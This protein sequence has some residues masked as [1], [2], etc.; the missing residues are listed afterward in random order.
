[1]PA[2]PLQ[3]PSPRPSR[4]GKNNFLFP[5]VQMKVSLIL[6]FVL[7]AMLLFSR[8]GYTQ[9][10]IRGSVLDGNKAP[11]VNATI[12]LLNAIDSSDMAKTITNEQG[13]YSFER[14]VIGDYII[15]AS[16]VGFEAAYTRAVS[17]VSSDDIIDARPIIMQSTSEQLQ[18]VV[19]RAK[20]PLIEQ[21]IDRTIIHVKSSITSAGITALDVL[22]R[23]PGVVVNRQNGLISM[24]GKEGVVVMINGKASYMPAAAVVQMLAGMTASNIDKVEL[25]TTPPANYD[26]EG[27][28]G[29]IN[30]VTTNNPDMGMNGSVSGSLGYGKGERAAASANFN[31]RKS[32]FNLYGDYSFTLD[33]MDQLFSFSRQ[34]LLNSQ[35]ISNTT[36][37]N[38]ETTQRNHLARI[39]FDFNLSN[40]TT[41]SGLVSMYNNR[42]SM[43]AVN[44]N[45]TSTN[46]LPDTSRRIAN[47]EINHWKHYGANVGIQHQLSADAR[48]VVN[49]DYLYY[50]DNNPVN[51]FN[52][53]FDNQGKLLFEQQTRSGKETP[54]KIWVGSVDYNQR[55]SKKVTM[56][57]GVKTSIS[58]FENNVLIE[59]LEQGDWV[60]DPSL[61]ARY[62]LNEDIVALYTSLNIIPD[63]K[64]EIKAG[65]RYEYTNSNLGTDEIKDVVDR[66][67]G[68]LFPGIFVTRKLN[69]DHSVGLSYSRRI[70]RPTFNDMAPFVIFIDPNTFFA[71]NPALR[72]AIGDNIKADYTFRKYLFSLSYNFNKDA[73]ARF[74]TQ[75]DPVANKQFFTSENL[76]NVKTLSAAVSFP[77]TMAAWWSMQSNITGTFQQVNSTFN[78][79]PL[80]KE[81]KSVRINSTQS[82]TLPKDF[83]VELSGFYQT[84]SLFGT[85]KLAGHGMFNAGIQKKIGKGKLRFGVDDVFNTF[86]YET[87]VKVPDENFISNADYKFTQRTYKLTYTR[88]F[89][90][91]KLKE[92][93]SRSMGSE[94]ERARVN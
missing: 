8:N 32:K 22:E 13:R 1:M 54:I 26:A 49:A 83:A 27:N 25:I 38:R 40:R 10:Q 84:A 59:K 91:D 17:I 31:Y 53:F 90:N 60:P 82:F 46:N 87:A 19:V 63:S 89:G 94:E 16:A 45:S 50:H 72:P 93:S 15:K 23:S 58:R 56:D 14:P 21:K 24:A 76:N 42:W 36:V 43:D 5:N 20:K 80:R 67:F 71:G 65:L 33:K 70:T 69:K 81:Q 73:I 77:I 78:G 12:F 75:I 4:S 34:L 6:M 64:T 35:K 28:A 57:A 7:S 30:I 55:W 44:N 92:R 29:F 68:K 79:A 47:D 37:S 11:V 62:K 51:Y 18:A 66:Q 52:S 9:S 74:Q 2:R 41:A 48:I 39:G 61:S 3:Q 88:S 86:I 85:A